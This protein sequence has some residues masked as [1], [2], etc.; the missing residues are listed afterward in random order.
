MTFRGKLE[1]SKND[2]ISQIICIQPSGDPPGEESAGIIL[3]TVGPGGQ[4]G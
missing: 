3:D 4:V 2:D 1:I